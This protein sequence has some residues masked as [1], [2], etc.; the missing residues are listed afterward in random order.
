MTAGLSDSA[1]PTRVHVVGRLAIIATVTVLAT[2]QSFG[3]F[4]LR[5]NTSPSLPI[6]IYVVTS[7]NSSS[8]VEFCPAEP[9]AT[10]S[11]ERGYRDR[12]SCPDGAAPLL[13]PVVAITG[14]SV[15]F[16][17]AGIAVNGKQLPNTAPLAVDTKGRPLPHWPFGHYLV[18]R[19]TVW[20]ASSHLPQ[21]FDSRYFGPVR[22]TLIREYLR[23][24]LT[25]W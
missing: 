20:V 3:L 12:G 1:R 18:S 4:G 9:L 21:S 25:E 8:L 13:K 24:L 6:G 15:E 10:V 5:L 17:A 14:D 2:F 16:S 7:G 23:P 19:G 11:I 22:K